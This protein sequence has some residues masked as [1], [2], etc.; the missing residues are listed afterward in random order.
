MK[1]RRE[2]DMKKDERKRRERLKGRKGGKGNGIE[3]GIGKVE[4]GEEER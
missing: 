2:R 4:K 1:R 3:R